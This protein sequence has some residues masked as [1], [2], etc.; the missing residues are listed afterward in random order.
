[1]AKTP[2]MQSWINQDRKHKT[3][4]VVIEHGATQSYS[5]A[6]MPKL[7]RDI[8]EYLRSTGQPLITYIESA[9]Y[10]FYVQGTEELPATQ[11]R[12]LTVFTVTYN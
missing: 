7:K 5:R 11:R 9:Q 10:D 6:V 2:K 1:M 8:M 12:P 4:T 3:L